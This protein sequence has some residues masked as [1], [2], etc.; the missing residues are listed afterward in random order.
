MR[1]EI[2]KCG[3][4][5][6]VGIIKAKRVDEMP[7]EEHVDLEGVAGGRRKRRRGRKN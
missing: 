2:H 7:Q 6:H 1:Y 4:W 3:S 5:H